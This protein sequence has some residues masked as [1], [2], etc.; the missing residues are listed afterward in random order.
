VILES[1][2]K[3][4][5]EE[6]C[7]RLDKLDSGLKREIDIDLN[8]LSTHTLIISGIR[9]CGKSTLLFQLLKRAIRGDTFY[10]NFEVPRLYGFTLTDFERLDKVITQNAANILFFDEIQVVEGWELYIRQKLDEG[11]KVIITGSNAS[12]LSKELGTKL[13]G[14]HITRELFPFSYTEYLKFRDIEKGR[15]SVLGYMQEGG[16]PEYLKTGDEE[17]LNQLFNDLLI[18]DIVVRYNIRDVRNLQLLAQFLISNIGNRITAGKLKQSFSISAISTISSWFAHIEQSYLLSFLPMYKTSIRAQAVNPRKVYAID[19]G[20]VNAISSNLQDDMGHKLENLVYLHLRK[21]YK[22]LYYFYDKVECDFI[23]FN[24]NNISVIL[25]VCYELN[26]DNLDRELNGILRA[27]EYFNYNNAQIITLNQRD[28]I[29]KDGK[30]IEVMPVSDYL[31]QNR[32][33]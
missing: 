9:R 27:M 11:F 7:S 18:R 17:V 31:S 30:I 4:V 16:F 32:D 14:R 20:L 21:R 10:I 13:T 25:Q 6:Q 26:Q 33:Y 12:L 2:I 19:T 15:E 29:K 28:V 1:T 24:K 23:A 5:Y 22:Q 8:E 3:K